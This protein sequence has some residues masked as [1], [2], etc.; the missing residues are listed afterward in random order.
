MKHGNQRKEA[1]GRSFRFPDKRSPRQ[2]I[3]Q[4]HSSQGQKARQV[5]GNN[6]AKTSFM[7]GNGRSHGRQDSLLQCYPFDLLY[8]VTTTNSIMNMA[9]I[10]ISKA[11]YILK[12][13]PICKIYRKVLPFT[14]TINF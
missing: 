14:N 9:L 3:D 1:W 4:H 5:P 2:C 8:I 6:L 11:H 7:P 10:C 13:N 12:Q